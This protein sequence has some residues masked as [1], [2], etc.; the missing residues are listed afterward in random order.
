MTRVSP[1]PRPHRLFW[2][3]LVVVGT[4]LIFAVAAMCVGPVPIE[5]DVT[6]LQALESAR[7]PPATDVMIA[8]TNLGMGPITAA[9]V[10]LVATWLLVR[11][12]AKEAGFLLVANL[13]GR[14]LD[15]GVTAMFARPRPPL[16]V[17]T[18]ITDPHSYSF[19]S[20]HALSAM[21]LYTSLAMMAAALDVPRLKGALVA[22][23]LIMVPTMGFTRLYLG[24][25]YPSDVIGG[26][27]LGA[28]WV[29]LVYLGYLAGTQKV[30]ATLN[31]TSSL[32]P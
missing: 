25:H 30:P 24:V 31:P 26:W 10:I 27:A 14:L 7:S 3:A 29:W 17:V 6:T 8:I 22:L 18:R 1:Q 21:V 4:A 5:S 15:L 13:G 12:H 23:A 32:L 2:P 19:P 11:R 9:F 28:A 16:D 20:G